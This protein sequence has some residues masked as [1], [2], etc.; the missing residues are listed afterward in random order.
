VALLV[1]LLPEGPR[2]YPEDELTDQTERMIAQEIIREKVMLVT[3]E[4][5]PYAVAVTVDEFVDKKKDLTV[6]KATIHIE[7]DTQ[8]PIVIGRGGARIK[9]IGTLA[10]EELERLLGRRVFLELFVRVQA[11]WTTN[12]RLLKE[13]GL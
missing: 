9:Q 2:Y 4:E 6:I 10:R 1:R 13:F 11:H 3:H 8:K 12:T 5:V 7:R